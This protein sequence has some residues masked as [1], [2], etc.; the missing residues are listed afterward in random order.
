MKRLAVVAAALCLLSSAVPVAAEES[1]FAYTYTTDL[2]PKS[3]TEAEQ[4]LTWRHQKS[5]GQFE[6]WE[7]RTELEYGVTD[8]FQM[9]GYLNYAM[10]HAFHNAP[11][12]TTTPPESFADTQPGPDD[13]FNDSRFVGVSVEGIYRI[14]SPYT[15]PIGF[16]VYLEPTIGR[17]LR[18]LETRLI[19]Q[20]NFLEDRLIVAS[21]ILL[22]QEGRYLPADPAA[23]PGDPEA[24]AHWDHETDLN[25]TLASSYRFIPN[26]SA[27]FE[28]M[29]E[30]EF[31]AFN[32]DGH[33]RTNSAFYLGPTIHYGGKSFFVTLT[34]L[35]QLPWGK[36]YTN[37]GLVVGGRNY[38]DDFER[39][40]M[41]LKIGYYF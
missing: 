5:Q 26:W 36:D 28:F 30:R 10:T 12:G 22:E 21:N 8:R 23:A 27:G 1:Q 20:K 6:V 32:I 14:L 37:S 38:A 24:N 16:A 29:N 3:K 41:R 25:F 17:N 15:D 39:Y 19:F 2:L 35:E 31:S 13:H 11:D 7:G 9:A 4:W 18:E 34:G 40:R 33:K